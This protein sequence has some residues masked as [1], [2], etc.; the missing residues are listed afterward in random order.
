MAQPKR[1]IP[2]LGKGMIWFLGILLFIQFACF[3]AYL[4]WEI[5]LPIIRG[6]EIGIGIGAG[7]MG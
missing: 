1:E 6:I 3:I 5:I 7:G 4:I 2:A